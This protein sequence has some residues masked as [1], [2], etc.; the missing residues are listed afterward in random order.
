LSQILVCADDYAIAPGVGRAI[1]RLALAGRIDAT[2]CMATS[3][4]WPE[5]GAALRALGAPIQ[6][7][8]HLTFTGVGRPTLGTLALA[9]F[10][11]RLDSATISAELD[12]QLDAFERVWG[13]PP[14][15]ID[16]HQ[17]VH[18]MPTIRR[19]VVALWRRRLDRR[20][21]WLRVTDNRISAILRVGTAPVKTL[22]IAALGRAM[23]HAAQKADIRTNDSFA[24]VY[25]F[26]AQIPYAVLFARM[27]AQARGWSVV[28][29]H[30]GE[31]DDALR[32]VDPVVDMRAVELDYFEGPDYAAL[33]AK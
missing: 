21:T 14:D 8:L 6:A 27:F 25:D 22:A 18:Q 10:S 29:C 20:Q 17:H 11:G 5:E 32:S 13:R 26:S 4:F 28:M 1:R 23:R 19:A 9:A 16:G 31:I 12:R 30:P 15:F 3:P 24:G 7:G 33:R 2:S